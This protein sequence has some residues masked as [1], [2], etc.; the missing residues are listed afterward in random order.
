MGFDDAASQL[1]IGGRWTDHDGEA[2]L[3]LRK[4]L[5]SRR[6]VGRLVAEEV[7]DFFCDPVLPLRVDGEEQDTVSEDVAGG[8]VACEIV[9]E[10]VAEDLAVCKPCEALVSRRFWRGVARF[11]GASNESTHQVSSFRGSLRYRL[12]LSLEHF[13]HVPLKFNGS[14]THSCPFLRHKTQ[15]QYLR[16]DDHYH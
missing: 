11:L 12:S 5:V 2:P 3:E 8:F 10:E 4:Q 7:P 6:L 16:R 1:E 13:R 15:R 9:Q 14:L